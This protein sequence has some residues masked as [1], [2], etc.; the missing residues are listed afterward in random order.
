MFGTLRL[1]LALV[2]LFSHVG[3]LYG[4]PAA[5]AVWS[6]FVLS[7]FLMTAVLNEKY[8]FEWKGIT[9]FASARFWRIY[10]TYWASCALG[11]VALQLL[12]PLHHVN[13]RFELP[14]SPWEWLG[15]LTLFPAY[16]QGRLMPASNAL[17]V[18]VAAYCTMP[19]VARKWWGGLALMLV[20]VVAT[21]SQGFEA[22]TFGIRYAGLLPSMTAFGAGSLAYHNRAWIGKA[23]LLALGCLAGWNLAPIVLPSSPWTFGLY[24]CVVVSAW[25][26]AALWS[27]Q[28]PAWDKALGDLSYP[29]YCYHSVVAAFAG[30]VFPAHSV[31]MGLLTAVGT[32]AVSLVSVYV[33]EP[34][35]VNVRSGQPATPK[36]SPVAQN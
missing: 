1:I 24:V 20:G 8:R 25:T 32:V 2:V 35:V 31:A 15:N 33:F 14:A 3:T 34:W 19:I 10:P 11:L 16:L 13:P 9:K 18:E 17:A 23:P 22:S 4:G 26:I 6:F 21:A 5:Y 28:P 7:G 36:A 12:G 29:V 30:Y 27:V